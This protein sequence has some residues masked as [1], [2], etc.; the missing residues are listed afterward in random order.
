MNKKRIAS[1]LVKIAYTLEDL[2]PD[3]EKKPIVRWLSRK[4]E[5]CDLCKTPLRPP[6]KF[7]YD[8]R[9]QM[10]PWGCGCEECFDQYGVGLGTGKGQKYDLKTLEKV[11]G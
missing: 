10:G 11:A 2:D 1:Q 3:I 5:K 4:P 8:F 9:T 7:F 6:E